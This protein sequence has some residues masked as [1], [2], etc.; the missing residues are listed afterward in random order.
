MNPI[1]LPKLVPAHRTYLDQLYLEWRNHRSLFALLAVAYVVTFLILYSR[2]GVWKSFL[3]T[4]LFTV[5]GVLTPLWL[6]VYS[7]RSIKREWASRAAYVFL[8]APVSPWAV[9]LAKLS[10]G[11]MG[12]IAL[13]VLYT[14]GLRAILAADFP[15]VY[16]QTFLAHFSDVLSY[17][18]I[19]FFGTWIIAPIVMAASVARRTVLRYGAF[20][21]WLFIAGLVL[22]DWVT[23]KLLGGLV[24]WNIQLPRLVINLNQADVALNAVG[25]TADL[26]SLTLKSLLAV[27]VFAVAVWM[28]SHRAQVTEGG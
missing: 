13:G 6:L 25:E 20:V 1:A 7:Y 18:S 28:W 5:A 15:E 23:Q 24:T 16:K 21:P 22:V 4:A 3:P 19:T 26:W 14:F 8:N 17:S 27:S 11:L 10:T 9:L 2:V 12:Y